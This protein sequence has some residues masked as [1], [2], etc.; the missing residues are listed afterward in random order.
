MADP[1]SS[2]DASD[3]RGNQ[4][5]QLS[6]SPNPGGHI[7]LQENRSSQE[8]KKSRGSTQILKFPVNR[9]D[10]YPAHIVFHPY[11]IDT[12]LVDNALGE[13]FNSPLVANFTEG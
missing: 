7:T 13:V 8:V 12:G 11:K 2:A 5:Q 10:M 4:I 9:Q 3:P 1:Y 6:S